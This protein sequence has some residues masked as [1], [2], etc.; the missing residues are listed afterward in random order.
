M[1]KRVSESIKEKNLHRLGHAVIQIYFK[2]VCTEDYKCPAD[3]FD[4]MS[5]HNKVHF[6]HYGQTIFR[7]VCKKCTIL[8]LE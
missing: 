8:K 3:K 1:R 7:T 6:I 4:L 5:L 2:Q